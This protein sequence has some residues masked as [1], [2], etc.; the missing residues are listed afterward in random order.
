M[1]VLRRRAF[2]QPASQATSRAPPFTP[3]ERP[4]V[5]ALKSVSNSW[6]DDTRKKKNGRAKKQE[7]NWPRGETETNLFPLLRITGRSQ[8]LSLNGNQLGSAQTSLFGHSD[9]SREKHKPKPHVS[10]GL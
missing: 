10:S 7:I 2:Y 4:E 9:L 5:M 8:P 6:K 1:Y 3:P